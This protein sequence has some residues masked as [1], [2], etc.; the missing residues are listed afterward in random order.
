VELHDDHFAID[1]ADEDWIVDVSF[2]GW[3]IIT[4]DRR[5]RYR[6]LELAAVREAKARLFV[7]TAGNATGSEMAD[8][9][10]GHLPR[11]QRIV[12]GQEPPFVARVSRASVSVKRLTK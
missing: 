4:K 12:N 11:M 8:I 1:A 3:A 2:R 6:P 9:L 5:I 7:L 10:V